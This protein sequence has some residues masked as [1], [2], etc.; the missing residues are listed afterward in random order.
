[1]KR[2]EP[3]QDDFV[4]DVTGLQPSGDSAL[5]RAIR[6]PLVSIRGFDNKC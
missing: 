4:I 1:M 5:D 3:S 6:S 2:Q